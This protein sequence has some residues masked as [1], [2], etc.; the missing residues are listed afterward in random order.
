MKK[1]ILFLLFAIVA[2]VFAQTHEYLDIIAELRY[3]GNYSEMKVQNNVLYAVTSYGFEAYNIEYPH[4]PQF[5][6]RTA[7]TQLSFDLD[8]KENV[9]YVADQDWGVYGYNMSDPALPVQ[10]FLYGGLNLEE[11]HT[12]ADIFVS[13]D[14]LYIAE[15]LEGVLVYDITDPLSPDYICTYDTYTHVDEII[16]IDALAYICDEQNNT[17]SVVDFS[18]CDNISV[19]NSIEIGDGAYTDIQVY[20]NYL[21][22]AN[23]NEVVEVIDISNPEDM[24]II[25]YI[26]MENAKIKNMAFHEDLLYISTSPDG[27][28][29][30]DVSDINNIS[31]RAN[32]NEDQW[33]YI[34][35][36]AIDEN[37]NAFAGFG[38]RGFCVLDNIS[39]YNSI[40]ISYQFSPPQILDNLSFYD[41]CLY[42][43]SGNSGGFEVIEISDI[44]NPTTLYQNDTLSIV[45]FIISDDGKVF[46]V[47]NIDGNYSMQMWDFTDIENP[48]IIFSDDLEYSVDKLGI[49]EQRLY[50][51]DRQNKVMMWDVGDVENIQFFNSFDLVE[52]RSTRL[53]G[54]F[55]YVVDRENT[56]NIIDISDVN[57]PVIVGSLN[58][59][60][61]G[62]VYGFDIAG[63]RAYLS[64]FAYGI[65]ELDISEPFDIQET[66]RNTAITSS[67]GCS[68]HDSLLYV[69]DH[70]FGIKVIN[71]AENL[72]VVGYY[73]SPGYCSDYDIN[74]GVCY[75]SDVFDLTICSFNP[76]SSVD[77]VG[78]LLPCEL[79]L[80]S[81]F[82]NPFNS[83]TTINYT[84]PAA[85]MVSLAVYD[86]S[87]REVVRLAEGVKPAGA[88]EAVWVADG[89]ASGVYVVKLVAGGK[90]LMSKVVL[91][92]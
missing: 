23:N 68:V 82:P 8:V 47:N 70:H 42:I 60:R 9:V 46:L 89:I 66:A 18:D 80:V 86:L 74:D 51:V 5:I 33:R 67:F 35:R 87:G 3:T 17:V 77:D 54:D 39:D 1:S 13:E 15:W 25:S 92:R 7:T 27:L 37:G 19:I 40:E 43:S 63:N 44:N 83:T 26:N 22:V 73:N 36:I 53:Y 30:Y 69:N 49:D 38:S 48:Q 72:R 57:T 21:F 20:D 75:M 79:Q 14:R 12:I 4:H 76:T 45:D 85:G 64:A 78:N 71:L 55:L 61:F 65:I 34:S 59:R 52:A 56:F 29:I 81:I 16:V 91:V 2:N 58:D 24:S 11:H 62:S 41:N 88:H 84:L 31:N 32:Y 90:A 6:S 50:G 28:I 10:V